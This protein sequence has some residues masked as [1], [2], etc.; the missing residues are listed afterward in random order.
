MSFTE[1]LY[2]GCD[3]DNTRNAKSKIPRQNQLILKNH[4]KD[5]LWLKQYEIFKTIHQRSAR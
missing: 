5:L 3:E 4:S 1:D 2:S